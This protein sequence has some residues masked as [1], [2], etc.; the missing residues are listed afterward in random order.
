MYH[1]R[2]QYIILLFDDSLILVILRDR[3]KV[4]IAVP[5]PGYP[6]I[7]LYFKVKEKMQ[8][9]WEL[10]GLTQKVMTFGGFMK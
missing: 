8:F 10:V 3:K 6:S 2:V 7:P 4:G 5:N 1:F 9:E